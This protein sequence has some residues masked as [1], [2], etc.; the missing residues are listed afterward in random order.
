MGKNIGLWS[1]VNESCLIW[2]L[3]CFLYKITNIFTQR[4]SK[5]RELNDKDIQ[6]FYNSI[7]SDELKKVKEVDELYTKFSWCKKIAKEYLMSGIMLDTQRGY[8]IDGGKRKIENCKI[9]LEIIDNIYKHIEKEFYNK[10]AKL[11]LTN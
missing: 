2:F 7:S 10:Q 9:Q 11:C 1:V 6:E 8:T 4:G 3:W 5:K